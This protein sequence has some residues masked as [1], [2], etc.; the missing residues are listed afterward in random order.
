MACPCLEVGYLPLR[1]NQQDP[2]IGSQPVRAWGPYGASSEWGVDGGGQSNQLFFMSL[3]GNSIPIKF[4]PFGRIQMEQD[5]VRETEESA[6]EGGRQMLGMWSWS[7]C[8]AWL[9]LSLPQ[10]SL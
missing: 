8:Q 10:L 7:K 9:L 4:I 1:Q 5:R 6:G 2:E 3:T